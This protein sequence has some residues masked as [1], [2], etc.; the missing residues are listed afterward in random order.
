MS[1][2]AEAPVNTK[3]VSGRRK[4]RYES[5]D[6]LLA[7][8]QRIAASEV[9]TLGNWS[10]GQIYMHLARSL[11]ASIDGFDF[12]MPAP[13]RWMMS[14]MMK[15]KFL[16]K[17]VPAGFK[18]PAGPMIPDET[19]TEEGLAALEAAIARQQ[20]EPERVIHP[21]FGKLTR[22]EWN[23]FHLRHAEMHMS[24]LTNG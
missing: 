16:H 19:S 6:D 18:A 9:K 23:L 5:M 20:R 3:K 22:E 10:P 24:F 17:E 21:G 14:L 7:D 13:V 1:A 8:A 12:S 11:D 4:V 15:N 2:I